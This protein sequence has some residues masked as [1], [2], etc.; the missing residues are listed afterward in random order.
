MEF[1]AEE[2][3]QFVAD[4]MQSKIQHN[5]L[6]IAGIYNEHDMQLYKTALFEGLINGIVMAGH[7]VKGIDV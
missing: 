3:L 4:H 2:L 7:K 6:E 1:T 5:E